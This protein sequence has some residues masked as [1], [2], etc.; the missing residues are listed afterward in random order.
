MQG[1]I[2]VFLAAGY[3]TTATTLSYVSY[4]LALN[5]DIQNRLRE[6]IEEYFPTKVRHLNIYWI[7]FVMPMVNPADTIEL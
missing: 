1:A 3:E 6:E 5:P 2:A 7:L 4:Y